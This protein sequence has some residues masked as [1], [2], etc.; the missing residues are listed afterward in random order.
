[1][2]LEPSPLPKSSPTGSG[3]SHVR[4]LLIFWLFVVSGVAF[5]DRVNISIA[6]SSIARDY[7]LTNVELGWV[8]SAFLAGYA[9][10]QTL[11]GRL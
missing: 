4:W 7:H 3:R 2:H 9:L 1:M 10:C 11:G 6:G 5:L 8:F